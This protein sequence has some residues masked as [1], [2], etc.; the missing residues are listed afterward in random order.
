MTTF[1]SKLIT[2]FGCHHRICGKRDLDKKKK[3]EITCNLKFS[4]VFPH[5]P[6]CANRLY[7]VWKVKKTSTQMS[8]QSSKKSYLLSWYP[9]WINAEM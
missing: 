5:V 9:G 3:Q 4:P 8:V 7:Y 2:D 1:C 6:D